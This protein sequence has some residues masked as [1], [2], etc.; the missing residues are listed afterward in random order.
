MIGEILEATGIDLGTWAI[1]LAI[2]WYLFRG[3]RVGRRAGSLLGRAVIDACLILVTGAVAMALGWA[4]LDLPHLL[5]DVSRLLSWLATDV[6]SWVLDL[7]SG[8]L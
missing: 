5:E 3:A 8:I 6:L 1:M 7:A 4:E 2:A